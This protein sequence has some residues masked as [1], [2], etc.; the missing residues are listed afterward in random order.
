ML[1]RLLFWKVL[2]E[3][4]GVGVRGGVRG[5]AALQNWG[6]ASPS[7]G[8]G[9]ASFT[10]AAPAS[11]VHW[12]QRMHFHPNSCPPTQKAALTGGSLGSPLPP[13][14]APTSA[15]ASAARALSSLLP[16][17]LTLGLLSSWIQDQFVSPP[18]RSFPNP[19]SPG[20]LTARCPRKPA[21]V[22]TLYFMF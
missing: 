9:G 5:G 13:Q 4:T 18:P 7:T 21:S 10:Q 11:R 2:K 6:E 19:S 22:H 12:L 20:Q 15:L 1:L 3:K 8:R 17:P 16:S 14:V